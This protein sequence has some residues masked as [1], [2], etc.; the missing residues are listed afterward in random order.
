MLQ[1]KI[2]SSAHPAP[3]AAAPIFFASRFQKVMVDTV[4]AWS[5]N[6]DHPYQLQIMYY[7]C[8]VSPHGLF[9]A[10]SAAGRFLDVLQFSRRLLASVV[11]LK[12]RYQQ[13]NHAIPTLV[14]CSE[15][16]DALRAPCLFDF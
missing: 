15:L 4:D 5:A 13:S 12:I 11:G 9:T 6:K 8:R 10:A 7:D 14:V 16:I 3:S 2:S 1:T